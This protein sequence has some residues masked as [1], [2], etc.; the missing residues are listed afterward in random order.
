[1]NFRAI[2]LFFWQRRW[3]LLSLCIVTPLGFSFKFY[4]G[5]NIRWF[6]DYGAGVM[7]EIFWCLVLFLFWPKKQNITKITIGVFC[8]TCFFEVLQLWHPWFL[9]HV[10]STFFGKALLGTTFVWW[11]FP[12]YLL[13][14]LISWVWMKAIIQL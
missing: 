12:H 2:S 1:M 6:H 8:I 10:R 4:R 7:Y 11:D 5:F 3:I 13:G 14:C 9:E